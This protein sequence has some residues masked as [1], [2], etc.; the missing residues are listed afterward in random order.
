MHMSNI[1][2]ESPGHSQE[3]PCPAQTL[4]KILLISVSCILGNGLKK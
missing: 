4:I 3:L 1:P 2:Q